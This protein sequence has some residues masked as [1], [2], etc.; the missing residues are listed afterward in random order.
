MTVHLLMQT[1]KNYLYWKRHKISRNTFTNCRRIHYTV[2]QGTPSTA[3]ED[4]ITKSGRT[5]TPSQRLQLVAFQSILKEH[6]FYPT[7]HPQILMLCIIT[8]K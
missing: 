1:I 6:D 3:I 5:F 7:K 8:K 4:Y 2:D